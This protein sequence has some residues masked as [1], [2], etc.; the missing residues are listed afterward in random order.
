MEGIAQIRGTL[1]EEGKYLDKNKRY[2]EV[3]GGAGSKGSRERGYSLFTFLKTVNFIYSCF[4]NL[5]R[6]R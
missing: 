4:T 2:C 3:S 5:S 6:L 1:E